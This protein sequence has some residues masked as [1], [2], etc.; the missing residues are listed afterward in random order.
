MGNETFYWDGPC[1][2]LVRLYDDD[3]CCESGNFFSLNWGYVSHFYGTILISQRRARIKKMKPFLFFFLH[4][5]ITS[6]LVC[7]LGYA[8]ERNTN[9]DDVFSRFFSRNLGRIGM[10]YAF[11]G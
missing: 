7:F 10:V 2:I 5:I 3:V 6:I 4:N 11:H 9:T 8:M 1:L